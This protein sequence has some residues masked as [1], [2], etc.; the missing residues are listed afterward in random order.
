MFP[1][2]LVEVWGW[3]GVTDA[4]LVDPPTP[5]SVSDLT[6]SRE[7]SRKQVNLFLERVHPRGGVTGWKAC[8]GARF[9]GYLVACLVLERPSARHA[10]DG[11]RVEISRYGIR[12]DRPANTGSWLI[13]RAR[14]WAALEGYAEI[15]TYAGVAGNKGVTYA[16]SGFECVDTTVADGSGWLTQ[17]DDR[18]TWDDYE[19]RKWVYKLDGA[20]V[21][22]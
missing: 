10:D 22:E 5:A 4:E 14:R 11:T 8:F 7:R 18:D 19:R 16:A 17:G 13:A 6:L 20:E 2:R 12:E 9:E 1:L 21:I 3:L 15:I